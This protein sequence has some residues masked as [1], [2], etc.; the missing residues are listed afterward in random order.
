MR[1]S[2]LLLDVMTFYVSMTLTFYA[3]RRASTHLDA[4]D[5]GH[6]DPHRR[7]PRPHLG[8]GAA[9]GSAVNGPQEIRTFTEACPSMT[10]CWA[11]VVVLLDTVCCSL[12]AEKEI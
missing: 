1:A 12:K 4:R 10:S 3:C 9:A 5:V 7:R 6:P 8:E 2:S 11:R